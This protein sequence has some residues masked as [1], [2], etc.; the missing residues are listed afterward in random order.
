L[1]VFQYQ[2]VVLDSAL[3]KTIFSP[4]TYA[5]GNGDEQ[6]T[7]TVELVIY[8]V[9]HMKGETLLQSL[10]PYSK[11]ITDTKTFKTTLSTPQN[12]MHKCECE[13]FHASKT[14]L[15]IYLQCQNCQVLLVDFI[16][17][18]SQATL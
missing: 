4:P 8:E 7:N 10:S 9:Q 11:G 3:T 15:Y 12:M 6:S 13:G 5:H 16:D 17:M 2:R 1:Y 18:L 14:Y